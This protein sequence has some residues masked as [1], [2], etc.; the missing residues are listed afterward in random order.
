METLLGIAVLVVVVWLYARAR[1]GGSGNATARRGPDSSFR[2][3][4][5]S[6]ISRDYA[7]AVQRGELREV[8]RKAGTEH[9]PPAPSGRA[10]EAW[11]PRT[12]QYEVAGEWYRAESLRALF[13]RH[14]NVSDAGAEI[15]L[16]AVLV[17]EPS[18]PFDNRAVAVFVDGF[19]VGYMERSD[20]A[21]YHSAIASLPGG[22]LIVP[23]RQWLRGAAHDTWARVTLSLPRPEDLS[24]PNPLDESA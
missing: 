6:A 18:N 21:T 2:S 14:A 3:E 12:Q 10:V 1:R 4:I 20:A 24:C 22:E 8:A 9:V 13:N 11:S 17:P 23:S 16:E 5:D 15:R 7:A 19:H